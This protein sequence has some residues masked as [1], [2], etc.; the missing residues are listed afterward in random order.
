MAITGE[1]IAKLAAMAKISMTEDEVSDYARSMSS[2][3]EIADRLN[4][5]DTGGVMPATHGAVAGKAC[6]EDVVVSPGLREE[7]LALAPERDE[8][9][10]LAPKV[11]D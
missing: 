6:R 7:L 10:F 1:T 8:T 5:L 4:L 3:A 11:L 2:M 9:C